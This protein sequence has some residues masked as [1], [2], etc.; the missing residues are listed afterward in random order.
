LGATIGWGFQLQDPIVVTILAVI[1]FLVGMNLIGFFEISG[2]FASVGSSLTQGNSHKASFF[3]GV[4][5]TLVA[6][7]CTAPFMAPAIGYALTQTPVISLIVFASLGF[8]LA[9]PYLLLTFIPTIQK[10]LP[11]PGLWMETFKQSLA[12]PM[13]ASVIWLVWVLVQQVGTTSI[14]YI[15]GLLLGLSFLIWLFKK[16]Q[17]VGLKFIFVILFLVFLGFF[18]NTLK[19]PQQSEEATFTQDYLNTVLSENPDKPVFVN[20]TAAWCITCLVNERA[21]LSKSDVKNAFEDNNVIYIKGDWTNRNP[22]ITKFLESYGRNGVPL[23]VY[24]GKGNADGIRPDAIVLP[25]ILTA[26]TVLDIIEGDQ[27]D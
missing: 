6:T 14:P 24:Y 15:L 21:S 16:V 9:F 12:F 19:S 8:G 4:L 26:Q 27:N 18:F 23:Y 20:M 11:K 3:T 10:I 22:E 13:L 1:L 5:A 2:R 7:P 25:Q 17:S